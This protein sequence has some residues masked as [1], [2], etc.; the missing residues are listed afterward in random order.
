VERFLQVGEQLDKGGADVVGNALGGTVLDCAVGPVSHLGA[1]G[2]G[3]DESFNRAA[4]LHSGPSSRAE[5]G[6]PEQESHVPWKR[7]SQVAHKAGK[8]TAGSNGDANGSSSCWEVATRDIC[9]P[10]QLWQG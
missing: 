8:V 5:E 4:H 9:G 2:G 1:S 6:I 10:C 7:S 3:G